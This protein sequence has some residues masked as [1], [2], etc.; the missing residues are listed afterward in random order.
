[1]L[2]EELSACLPAVTGCEIVLLKSCEVRKVSPGAVPHQ[3]RRIF[4]LVNI[5]I[6]R[7]SVYAFGIGPEA[8]R[9]FLGRSHSAAPRNTSYLLLTSSESRLICSQTLS[10]CRYSIICY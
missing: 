7:T 8:K 2:V 4:E 6:Q 5:S 1:M 10:K 3:P 9:T